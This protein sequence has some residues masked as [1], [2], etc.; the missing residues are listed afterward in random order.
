MVRAEAILRTFLYLPK[1][2]M[3]GPLSY[4]LQHTF[5]ASPRAVSLVSLFLTISTPM[6]RRVCGRGGL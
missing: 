2:I 5:I 1:E 4:V 6:R 3:T